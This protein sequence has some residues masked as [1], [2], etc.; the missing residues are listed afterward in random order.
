MQ[1]PGP[2]GKIHVGHCAFSFETSWS[3]CSWDFIIKCKSEFST[4]GLIVV[5]KSVKICPSGLLV[6]VLPEHLT[7]QLV[8]SCCQHH[9]SRKD[10]IYLVSSACVA[11]SMLYPDYCTGATLGSLFDRL[12]S[13]VLQFDGHS[14]TWNWSGGHTSLEYPS[15]KFCNHTG[16]ILVRF[17]C[18]TY[19]KGLLAC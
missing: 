10:W 15:L 14:Y 16:R 8:N 13:A 18:L 6:W 3:T 11:N 17:Y 7:F 9:Q 4:R 1:H 12:T 5:W 2:S 19:I